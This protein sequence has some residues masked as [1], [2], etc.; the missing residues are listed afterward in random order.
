MP[1]FYGAFLELKRKLIKKVYPWVLS[2]WSNR[3][4]IG[5]ALFITALGIRL[6]VEIL[7]L[8]RYT[9]FYSDQVRDALVYQSMHHGQWPTLGPSSSFNGFS[10]QFSSTAIRY[11]V[12]GATLCSIDYRAVARNLMGYSL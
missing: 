6:I 7:P 11:E 12:S 5:W 8:L 1:L 4:Y 3:Y 10:L 9:S 2:I